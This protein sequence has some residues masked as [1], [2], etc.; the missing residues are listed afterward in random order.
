MFGK[1]LLNAALSIAFPE[2]KETM[3]PEKK[4]LPIYLANNS[5]YMNENITKYALS[6]VLP[7]H[8]YNEITSFKIKDDQIYVIHSTLGLLKIKPHSLEFQD[9]MTLFKY[10]LTHENAVQN[11]NKKLLIGFCTMLL[12]GVCLGLSAGIFGAGILTL[13]TTYAIKAHIESKDLIG[14]EKIYYL[15]SVLNILSSQARN[16]R[17]LFNSFFYNPLK[18]SCENSYLKS[19]FSAINSE[20]QSFIGNQILSFSKYYLSDK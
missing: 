1:L 19:D 20:Q 9:D 16:N 14:V 5:V 15:P 7:Q 3:K 8:L 17:E 11:Y 13:G 2:P 12:G 10:D 18:I 6:K 4:L